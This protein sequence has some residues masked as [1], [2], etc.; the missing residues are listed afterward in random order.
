MALIVGLGNPGSRYEDTRHN[1]GFMV[2]DALA[3]ELDAPP[4]KEWGESLLTSVSL[5]SGKLI[6]AK[7][8]T[9]INLSGKAVS[10]LIHSF[11]LDSDPF[12]VVHDDMHIPFGSLRIKTS[13]SSGG[14]NGVRSV[15]DSLGSDKFS[16]LKIGVGGP[17]EGLSV[18][19]F[20]LAPFTEAETKSLP[21]FIAA[22]AQALRM[23]VEEGPQ[24]AMNHFHSLRFE[25]Q[26]EP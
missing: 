13:G 15:I 26:E 18:V 1:A 17:S 7:P 22:G 3:S 5:Q 20:V 25:E 19:D 9:Y 2:V 24:W 21:R 16:R 14:H 12:I 11:I 23:L 10:A 4:W 8:L 6:L